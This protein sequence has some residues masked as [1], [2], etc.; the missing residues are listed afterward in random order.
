MSS[1]RPHTH[2]HPRDGAGS[3]APKH[4]VPSESPDPSPSRERRRRAPVRSR[5][6]AGGGWGGFLHRPETVR[7]EGG[8]TGQRLA[9]AGPAI[10]GGTACLDP[11]HDKPE[12]GGAFGSEGLP[13][14]AGAGS[15]SVWGNSAGRGG[16]AGRRAA[17]GS[18]ACRASRRLIPGAAQIKPMLESVDR[19]IAR[20][21]DGYKAE[22]FSR[23]RVLFQ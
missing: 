14:Q 6:P 16:G 5:M 20:E 15:R 12:P 7:E 17:F 9:P 2:T 13:R 3:G 10:P 11:S 1:P 22:C 8:L 23:Q 4:R 21:T 18:F 19:F